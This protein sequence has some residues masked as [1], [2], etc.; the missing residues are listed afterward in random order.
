MRTGDFRGVDFLPEWVMEPGRQFA[1]DERPKVRWVEHAD[2][3]DAM[4]LSEVGAGGAWIR[5]A[6]A[7]P[8]EP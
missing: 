8:V 4:T 1:P 2:A 3:P 6:N 5:A 7:V